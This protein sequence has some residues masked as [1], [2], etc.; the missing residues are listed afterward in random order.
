MKRVIQLLII[1]FSGLLF[2][3]NRIFAQKYSV[4][5]YTENDGLSNSMVFD[6]AQDPH[7]CMWFATRTGLSR[8]DGLIWE[9]FSLN[10]KLPALAYNKL[11]I[12]ENGVVWALAN[13]PSLLVSKFVNAQWITIPAVDSITT[14]THFTMF[15]NFSKNNK[16]N[17]CV[18]TNNLGI[19]LFDGNRWTHLTVDNGLPDNRINSLA[20]WKDRVYVAT[21]SGISVLQNRKIENYFVKSCEFPKPGVLGLA[22]ESVIDNSGTE[23]LRLWII[24]TN[25][26]GRIENEQFMLLSN[27]IPTLADEQC[28]FELILP[29]LNGGV[30]YGNKFELFHYNGRLKHLIQLNRRSGLLADGIMGLYSDRERNL[31]IASFRGVSKI[32]SL[33]FLNYDESQGLLQNEVTAALQRK[34]GQYVFGHE[35]GLTFLDKNGFSVYKFPEDE[36]GRIFQTRVLDLS[37]DSLDNLWI[38]AS[39][40]GLGKLDHQG[41]ITWYSGKHGL[42]GYVSGVLCNPDGEIWAAANNGLCKKVGN[43]FV[44]FVPEKFKSLYIRRLMLGHDNSFYL[45]TGSDGVLRFRDGQ[46][47]HYFIENGV[48]ENK[49]YTLA[50][51]SEKRIWVGTLGGLFYLTENGLEKFESNGFHI[52]RPVYAINQD[53]NHNLWFGTDNGIYKF[54]GNKVSYY[55]SL[56]GLVGREVNR[57]ATFL[58]DMGRIW[59]GTESGISCYQEEF[60]YGINTIP[61]PLINLTKLEIG[62]SSF[63]LTRPMTF[64]SSQNNFNFHYKGI[65]FIDE[66]AVKYRCQLQGFDKDWI[67]MNNASERIIRYTNLPPGDYRFFVQVQNGLGQWSEPA[68]SEEIVVQKPFWNQWWFYIGSTLLFGFILLSIQKAYAKKKYTKALEIEVKLRTKSLHE[69]EAQIRTTIDSMDEI[70]FVVDCELLLLM[71]NTRF[72]QMANREIP[73]T[74]WIQRPVQ[75]IFPLLNEKKLLEYHQ[76]IRN[77]ETVLTEDLFIFN[78]KE[79]VAET[80]KIPIIEDEQVK[81]ILTVI[82]DITERKQTEKN[83]KLAKKQAEDA[84]RA[85]SEF[86]ANMSHEIRT[87]MN[88][89]I[90]LTDLMLETPMNPQQLK[91]Q[92]MVRNS[93]RHLLSVLNDIL[94]F[95]KIEAGQL[96]LEK[97]EFDLRSILENV[98]DVMVQQAELKQIELNLYIQ[99]NVPAK[100]LGDS[101]RLKQIVLNLLGNAIKFTEKGEVTLFVRLENKKSDKRV[102]L[103]FSVKDTG[104]GIPQERLH[105]IFESFTQGDTSTTRKFGGTGLGLTIVRQLVHMMDG[106]IWVESKVQRGSNFQFTIEL[107][108]RKFDEKEP[109]VEKSIKGKKVL[110][111]DDNATSRDILN[112]I[113]KSVDC[114]ATLFADGYKALQ[115]LQ[116]GHQFDLAI[117][118]YQMPNLTG[119]TIVRML[120]QAENDRKIPIILLSPLGIRNEI[121]NLSEYQP[122]EVLT[123]PIKQNELLEIMN[124]ILRGKDEQPA[125]RLK[126]KTIEPTD[127]VSE[128]IEYSSNCRF[129]LVEDNIINQKVVLA[130]LKRV[131]IETDVANNGLEAL[132]ALNTNQYNLILMDVQMPEMDGLTATI[133]IRETYDFDS[134]PIIALTAHAMKG[135]R[136]KCLTVGMNDYLSKPIQPDL[137]FKIIHKWIIARERTNP[138][139]IV[140]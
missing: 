10:E 109:A 126:I 56:Q 119:A 55:S 100:V 29:D 65:S 53:L 3:Q 11:T 20:V 101:A 33:R 54:D 114:E 25:W 103:Y 34:S 79:F 57:A 95:S 86:L 43:K 5:T 28:H 102:K 124:K 41:N 78:E 108:V 98:L 38:A 52:D 99:Q 117:T 30:F 83:L 45:A 47:S 76:V 116:A 112:D 22:V 39:S 32:P 4:H 59:F 1:A 27:K 137:L 72:R 67:E 115:Y 138:Q 7:G 127:V 122:I 26:L 63:D 12:G 81:R 96:E 135:D 49:P 105:A 94:D 15:V 92:R 131:H 121:E 44:S 68:S 48:L 24:G 69:S 36:L 130:V 106:E 132:E 66:T 18:G 42:E 85:K 111:I 87:P 8:F 75:E 77:R 118:D 123:K 70:V 13:P 21:D 120:R 51:D 6:V 61:K 60:D 80:R 84:N 19:Y 74:E 91:Y 82:H 23:T 104:I 140:T 37:L 17:L 2:F 136:E 107:D 58:D 16:T 134:L 14:S 73:E 139:I 71:Y 97:I 128:L 35:S 93:A 133:K 88:G 90:G 129:L 64:K 62:Q 110:V 46:W 125:E 9:R 89:I 31:W 113:L 40:L 50:E